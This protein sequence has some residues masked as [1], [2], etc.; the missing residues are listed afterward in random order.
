MS[1]L[2]PGWQG[3]A[4]RLLVRAAAGYIRLV[5]ASTRWTVEGREHFDA[6]LKAE[7]AF[8]VSMWHGR[9]FLSPTFAPADWQS[10]AMISNSRDGD[11]IAGIVARFGVNAVRGSTHDRRKGRDK[12]GAQA[13]AE[14]LSRLSARRSVMVVTPDG[15]RGPRMKA[16]PGIAAIAIQRRIAV[17]PVAFSARWAVFGRGWDRFLVPLPFGH[18]AIVFEPSI[19]ADGKPREALL[20][21]IENATCKAT[22]RA[23]LLCGQASAP[24]EPSA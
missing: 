7:D 16:Q 2:R 5:R 21:E 9:L 24:A 12:G 11:L 4:R 10:I 23:D 20:A 8:V 3:F 19:S 22:E 15:P 6:L 14:A 17:L 18:G 13:Y 1:N